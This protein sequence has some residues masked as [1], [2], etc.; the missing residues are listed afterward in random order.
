[1]GNVLFL[2][3]GNYYRSRFAEILFNWHATITELDVGSVAKVPSGQGA[4]ASGDPTAK[5]HQKLTWR[6]DSRGLALNPGNLGPMSEFTIRRLNRLQVPVDQYLRYPKELTLN[7]LNRA[8]HIVAVKAA[9]HR[10]LISRRFP[11]WLHKIEYWD[12]HDVDCEGP[13]TALPQLEKQVMELL[14]RLK[15]GSP[16]SI[17]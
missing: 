7:D 3:T 1:M 4:E 12:I 5:A 2:C 10:P 8:D 9:E 17:G 6:A 11:D 14:H 13:D 16:E 15:R